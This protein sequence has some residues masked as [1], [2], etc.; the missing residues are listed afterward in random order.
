MSDIVALVGF[1]L[2]KSKKKKILY[3]CKC[4]RMGYAQKTH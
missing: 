2:G 1:N 3:T 4:G